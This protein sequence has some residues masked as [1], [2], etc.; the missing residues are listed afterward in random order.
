M[1]DRNLIFI[2]VNNVD[3]FKSAKEIQKLEDFLSR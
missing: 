2:A 1:R 3:K